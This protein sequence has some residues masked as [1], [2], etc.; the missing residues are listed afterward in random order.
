MS[1][2]PIYIV[3]GLP[4]SGTSMMMKMLEAGGLSVL[5]DNIRTADDDNLQGYYELE[6]VKAMKEGDTTW[7]EE[8]N[9]KVVKVISALLEHLPAN[10]QYKIIFMEREMMEILASQRKMLERRGKPGDPAEDGKFAELYGKHLDK[11][12]TWLVGRSNMDVLYVRYNE[13]IAHPADYA[14]KVAEFLD[15]PM[16]VG[17]MEKVPQEQYYR[18]RK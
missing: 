7:V 17:T 10:Y 6:R 2:K 16:D 12:K 5:T 4:R 8:A 18:Q 13:M 9:G 15:I 11:V 3:S 1:D 14:A